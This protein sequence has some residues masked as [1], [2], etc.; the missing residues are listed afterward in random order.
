[1]TG[2]VIAEPTLVVNNLQ[3]GYRRGTHLVR[4]VRNVSLELTRGEILGIVGESGSGK[5]TLLMS[6]IGLLP[7]RAAILGGSIRF[8][9]TEL[10]QL[11]REE[12][13]R[14]RGVSISMIPQRPM[15]SLSPV[16]RVGTQLHRLIDRR[17]VHEGN[18]STPIAQILS[19]VG[20]R[21][22][23][24]RLGGYPHEFSGGQLQRLLIS[25]AALSAKPEIL[26]A[27]EP[28]S[29][30]DA[31]IQA[32]VLS[33]L[34][35]VRRELGLAIVF[36]SHDLG[37][38]A[39]VCDRVGVMYAGELVEVAD[40]S[41]FFTSP[42]HPYTQALLNSMPSRHSTR[43]LLPTITGDVPDLANVPAGCPFHPRCPHAFSTC[44]DTPP[45]NQ[46]VGTSVVR[47]HLYGG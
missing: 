19:Q 5:S 1:M 38:V 6:I 2:G 16:A 43:Q 32:Q 40:V 24:E 9:D 47:C 26:L 33:L 8:H 42:C 29:T 15:S 34:M 17:Q 14:L 12:M 22:V 21:A 10:T 35:Q 20:L 11:K 39:Q 23:A 41:S 3:V 4:A 18:R 44:M 36:V 28:T 31:T 37:V 7:A 45:A 27:D 13:R 46:T 25:I 30:L